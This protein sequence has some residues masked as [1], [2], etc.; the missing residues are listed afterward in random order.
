MVDIA[1]PGHDGAFAFS[2]L[3]AGD[4]VL[5]AFF[6]GKAVGKPV[7]VTGERNLLVDLKEPL[8]VGEGGGQ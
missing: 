2:A 3:P 4:Y 1:Y 5:K 7:S 6:Q 8:N